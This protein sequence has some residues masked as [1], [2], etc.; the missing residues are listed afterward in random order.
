MSIYDLWGMILAG[1]RVA[2]PDEKH[3][4]DPEKWYAL[5]E[6][7]GVTIWNSVPAILEM[8]LA[9]SGEKQE[10][11]TVRLV[12]SGGDFL[13]PELSRNVLDK[14]SEPVLVNVGGPTETTL[15]N[16]YHIVTEED[17]ASGLI[18]YAYLSFF[19]NCLRKA[20]ILEHDRCKC[21]TCGISD[22]RDEDFNN[23]NGSV[24]GDISDFSCIQSK[25]S[26][27]YGK[28]TE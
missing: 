6:K 8:L 9:W 20:C 7:A 11:R 17:I 12:I 22:K 25:S 15:W 3:F 21:S 24:F 5:I 18:P 10:I 4:K 2:V 26:L 16:I 19:M 23:I 13:S 27:N 1:G 14:M 28:K